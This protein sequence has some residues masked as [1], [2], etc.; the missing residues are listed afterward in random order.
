MPMYLCQNDTSSKGSGSAANK[1]WSY[2]KTGNYDV[3]VKWG[4]V[5]LAGQSK[6][7][8]FGSAGEQEKFIQKKVREKQRKGYA[9]TDDKQMKKE[10][11]IA[12]LMG[13]QYKIGRMQ[14]V[15][16]RG[17]K[18]KLALE[19]NPNEYVYVEILNSWSKEVTRLLLAKKDSW[20]IEGVA[21]QGRT[22]EYDYESRPNSQF[23]RGVREALKELARKVTEAVVKFAAMGVRKLSLSD[24]DDDDEYTPVLEPVFEAVGDSASKQV[25]QKFA[26]LGERT[27]DL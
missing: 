8:T 18:L 11:K 9:L 2:E 17:K 22:I 3:L 27:L 6:T 23:V 13:A 12:S 1:F 26:A 16:K 20:E 19:Y 5:G 24:D 4:R 21:E 25:V 14:W 7:H 10:T 15:T